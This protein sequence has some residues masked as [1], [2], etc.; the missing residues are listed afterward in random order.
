MN[1]FRVVD[2]ECPT[3][4]LFRDSGRHGENQRVVDEESGRNRNDGVEAHALLYLATNSSDEGSSRAANHPIL[5]I[6]PNRCVITTWQKGHLLGR[7]SFGS[8]YEGITE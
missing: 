7:G 5:I 8:V 1:R 3:L 6:S 4:E 2:T